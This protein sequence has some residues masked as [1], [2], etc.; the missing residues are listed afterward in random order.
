M[1]GPPKSSCGGGELSRLC[2]SCSWHAR[3]GG[4]QPRTVVVGHTAAAP[5][6]VEP[7][8]RL[9]AVGVRSDPTSSVPSGAYQ[10]RR[11][12]SSSGRVSDDG[13]RRGVRRRHAGADATGLGSERKWVPRRS[14]TRLCAS[15]REAPRG[16]LVAHAVL[17]RVARPETL[18]DSPSGGCRWH[19]ATRAG[20]RMR[21][22]GQA[23]AGLGSS[24]PGGFG[25]AS[26][27]TQPSPW[28]LPGVGEVGRRGSVRRSTVSG[29]RVGSQ[30]VLRRS[31]NI[32]GA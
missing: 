10:V 30:A 14:G 8:A 25:L 21:S 1:R 24:M 20:L 4:A 6:A 3:P 29:S 22:N 13:G 18:G 5:P 15:R 9:R 12:C 32:R 28:T 17:R 27:G 16:R 26:S 19:R 31:A 7:S 23:E 2:S 11:A